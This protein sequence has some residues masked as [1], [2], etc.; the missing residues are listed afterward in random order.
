MAARILIVDDELGIASAVQMR[1]EMEGYQASIV[2]DGQAA[3]EQAREDHP[4]L[5][6]LDVMI[7]KIDGME[8]CRVLKTAPKTRD[9][10]IIMLTVMSQV[11]DLE[12]AFANGA[13]DYLFK[14]FQFEQLLLKVRRFV[15]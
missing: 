13:N 8:V 11:R 5:I 7:P 2:T 14:P 12:K 4:S 9:I 10:P 3:I 1:L 6:L 15:K